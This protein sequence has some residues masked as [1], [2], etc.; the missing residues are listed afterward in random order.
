[1]SS[2]SRPTSSSSTH[3]SP[4][5]SPSSSLSS[6]SSSLNYSTTEPFSVGAIQALHLVENVVKGDDLNSATDQSGSPE[7]SS[8]LLGLDL[9]DSKVTRLT[10]CFLRN[11]SISDFLGRVS[12]LKSDV[13]HGIV[14]VEPC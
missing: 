6:S 1:M 7:Q 13:S 11:T 5:P 8:P 4:L 3:A 10:S 14:T 2:L 12:V 9:V